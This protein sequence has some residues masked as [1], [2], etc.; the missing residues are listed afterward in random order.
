M[1][2]QTGLDTLSDGGTLIL[3]DGIYTVS[4]PFNLGDNYASRAYIRAD[5][6]ARPILTTSDT[7]CPAVYVGAFCEVDG[8]WFG[9][10]RDEE[11][12]AQLAATGNDVTIRNCVFF[13]YLQAIGE[14]SVTRARYQNN[15]FIGCGQ[16]TLSHSIYISDSSPAH[17][18]SILDNIFI[19]GA[20][21]HIHLWHKPTNTDVRYNFS[22]GADYCLV[23]QGANHT[24]DKNVWWKPTS[25]GYPVFLDTGANKQYTDNFHGPIVEGSE[26]AGDKNWFGETSLP[27]GLTMT[28][29]HYMQGSIPD[30]SPTVVTLGDEANHLGK[31]AAQ[32]DAA[33][34]AL[35]TAF[36]QTVQQIHDDATIETHFATLKAVIDTWK[37]Q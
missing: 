12:S 26:R 29:N 13:N 28:G 23:P 2:L 14:G 4:S 9:G 8:L 20:A 24:I 19:G 31:T 7:K 21:Y 16:G 30:P 11:Q 36:A 32:I 25:P 18:A 27:A 6:G 34:S 3:L 1:D 35:E 22:A 10:V 17:R 5:A 15:K 37:P 33:I